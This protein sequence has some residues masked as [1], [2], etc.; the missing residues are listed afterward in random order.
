MGD[1]LKRAA[2]ICGGITVKAKGETVRHN[3]DSEP[4]EML[5]MLTDDDRSIIEHSLGIEGKKG[6][7]RKP[8]RNHYCADAGNSRLDALAV[9]GLMKRGGTINSGT[10]R[11][12]YVTE[13]GAKS[14]G[15]KLPE[16][17]CS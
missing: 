14:V 12:F 16:E 10:M 4:A 17:A 15:S 7:K 2:R 6:Q 3:A 5:E 13:A 8:Y 11:Y 9:R 1:G